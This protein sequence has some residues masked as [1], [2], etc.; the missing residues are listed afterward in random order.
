MHPEILLQIARTELHD[1]LRDAEDRRLAAV[2]RR[3]TRPGGP[4]AEPRRKLVFA[5][6]RDR[7]A[8]RAPVTLGRF[9]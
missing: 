2:A 3:H 9:T 7:F 1:R 5:R 4:S 8:R 6:R